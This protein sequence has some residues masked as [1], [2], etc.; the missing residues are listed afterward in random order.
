M[1]E[2]VEK[3]PGPTIPTAFR[4]LDLSPNYLRFFSDVGLFSSV[5]VCLVFKDVGVFSS[6][7]SGLILSLV[8]G[9]IE[10]LVMGLSRVPFLA[11]TRFLSYSPTVTD[12]ELYP[13]VPTDLTM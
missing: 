3:P 2:D 1:P 13:G 4:F 6:V 7:D 12:L 8:T 10:R 5:E 9:L 11:L